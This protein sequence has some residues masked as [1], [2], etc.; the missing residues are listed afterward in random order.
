[1]NKLDECFAAGGKP[2]LNIYCTAGFPEVDSLPSMILS[3]EES[4]VDIVEVGMPYSD[5]IADGPTI[6]QSNMIALANGITI[7]K[8]LEQINSIKENVQIPLILMG[9]LNPVL[10]YGIESFC[11]DA[12]AAGVSGIILPDLPMEE[13]ETKFQK[14]FKQYNLH[15][16]L[17]VTP[18]TSEKRIKKADKLSGGFIYAVSSSA[19]TGNT[20]DIQTQEH[21]FKKLQK[22]GLKNPVLIGFGIHNREGFLY[23]NKFSSGA[24]IGSAFIKALMVEG[25]IKKNSQSFVE[26]ILQG[27]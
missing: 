17:L 27:E 18:Q 10:Q 9:Y 5:P 25:D 16:I 1:M 7:Q 3:L 19:T 12:A 15:F 24:I 13:F 8:I 6:Q 2:I 22:L 14:L 4:G 21:Y 23:A 26:S 20:G 11:K